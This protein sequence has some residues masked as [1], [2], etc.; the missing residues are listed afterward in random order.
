MQLTV[1]MPDEFRQ[2]MDKLSKRMG[3]KRS[4][5]VRLALKRFLEEESERD[6]RTPFQR[7]GQLVGSAES[8]IKDLGQRHRYYLAQRLR[9]AS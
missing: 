1:R 9:K 6:H 2:K 3:L 5:I 4:D 8:G 7:V